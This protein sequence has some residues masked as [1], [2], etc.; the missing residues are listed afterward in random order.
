MSKKSKNSMSVSSGH[1]QPEELY[2]VPQQ[3]QK[4]IITKENYL[5]AL[6]NYY[7]EHKGL[8]NIQFKDLDKKDKDFFEKIAE[9]NNQIRINQ[10]EEAE[11]KAKRREEE[12]EKKAKRREEEAKRREEEAKRRAKK[13]SIKDEKFVQRKKSRKLLHFTNL[14]SPYKRSVKKSKSKTYKNKPRGTS[15]SLVNKFSKMTI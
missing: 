15:S 3:N 9:N 13:R 14:K 12:A 1:S 8:S 4:G 10:K 7:N 6:S 5:N 2:D 11:K